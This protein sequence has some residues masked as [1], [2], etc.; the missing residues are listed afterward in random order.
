MQDET[1]E[2]RSRSCAYVARLPQKGMPVV[3]DADERQRA[4]LADGT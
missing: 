2:R 1:E 4:A 3:I